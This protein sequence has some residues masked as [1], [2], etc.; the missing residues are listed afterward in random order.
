MKQKQ[1]SPP[2]YPIW[3]Y[4]AAPCMLILITAL[5][6]FP[7]LHY[8]FQFDDVANIQKH[9]NIRN[10]TLW[11]LFFSGSRWISYWL[12]A[13]HYSIGKFDPFSYRVGNVIIHSLN[14]LLVFQ[15]ISMALAGLKR[16]SFFKE[17][18]L[19]IGLLTCALFLLHPVQTQ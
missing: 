18:H 19:T 17:Q 16:A 9:F 4:Y 15:V 11:K 2:A 3:Y 12:N 5:F 14:G 7:S 13:M 8:A 1:V 10:Y 6:Y